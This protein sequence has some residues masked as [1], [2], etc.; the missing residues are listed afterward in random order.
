MHSFQ[1]QGNL[2]LFLKFKVGKWWDYCAFLHIS[3][4]SMLVL[5]S[6]FIWWIFTSLQPHRLKHEY[7]VTNSLFLKKAFV[8]F[9]RKFFLEKFLPDFDLSLKK[10]LGVIEIYVN[11]PCLYHFFGPAFTPPIHSFSGICKVRKFY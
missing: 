9:L 10:E 4:K 5:V 8:K 2:F 3:F 6:L 1:Q 7:S 11:S